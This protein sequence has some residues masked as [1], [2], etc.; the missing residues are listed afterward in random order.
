MSNVFI[1][2]A[3]LESIP[4]E[5][6]PALDT[7]L[8]DQSIA[9]LMVGTMKS[10]G[11]TFIPVIFTAQMGGRIRVVLYAL[12]VPNLF[13]G[14]FIGAS[15][16]RNWI[17]EERWRGGVPSYIFDFGQGGKHEVIGISR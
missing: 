12:V 10:I 15:A 9:T 7:T 3:L 6:R 4:S 8:A 16:T 2:K 1:Y 11:T 13:M 5:H 17:K 14:M